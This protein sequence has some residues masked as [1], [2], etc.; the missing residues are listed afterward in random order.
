MYRCIGSG[1][2]FGRNGRT[3]GS[4]ALL[5]ILIILM[6][7]VTGNILKWE[8]ANAIM[9][10]TLERV[11]IDLEEIQSPDIVEI[12]QHK[13]KK[14]YELLGEPALCEDVGLSFDARNGLPGP[15]IKWFLKS[16]GNE[17]ILHMLS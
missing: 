12:I 9:G 15:W 7:F 3:L 2:I 4:D 13:S 8:E 5:F 6:K 1:K 17:G 14:A 16:V 11:D 10:G